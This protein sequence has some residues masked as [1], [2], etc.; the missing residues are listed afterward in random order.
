MDHKDYGF[1]KI[2]QS[3]EFIV[4]SNLIHNTNDTHTATHIA[5]DRTSTEKD[6]Y[7]IKTAETSHIDANIELA[8]N[9]FYSEK[10][11]REYESQD[12]AGDLKSLL[13]SWSMLELYPC[14]VRKFSQF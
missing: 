4:L 3:E 5:Q 2:P 8:S 9:V 14:F 6:A 12:T 11:M 13:E 1:G 10:I 7:E